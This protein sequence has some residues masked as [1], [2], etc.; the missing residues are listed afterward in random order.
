MYIVYLYVC[1]MCLPGYH[2]NGFV[3]THAIEHMMYDYYLIYIHTY[4]L[5]KKHFLNFY[6]YFGCFQNLLPFYSVEG[7]HTL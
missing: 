7:L 1:T 2:H 6:K 3:A 5:N 4:I